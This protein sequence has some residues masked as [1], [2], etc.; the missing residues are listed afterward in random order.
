MISFKTTWICCKC[1]V[2]IIIA[3]IDITF[4]LTY[5]MNTNEGLME[6]ISN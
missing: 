3:V 5:P 4:L 6:T 1:F 2:K